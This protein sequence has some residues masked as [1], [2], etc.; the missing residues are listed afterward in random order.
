MSIVSDFL[1]KVSGTVKQ[2]SEAQLRAAQ[3]R[4]YTPEQERQ[5]RAQGFA[6]AEAM[7]EFSRQRQL[8]R[9]VT[10]R[11]IDSQKV[12]QDVTSWHPA[13]MLNNVLNAINSATG[14]N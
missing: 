4:T 9:G 13:V 3:K 5:A 8:K 11:K 10:D 14:G 1:D 2:D 6:N 7:I 12:R